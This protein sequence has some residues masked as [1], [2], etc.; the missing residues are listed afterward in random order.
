[1]AGLLDGRHVLVVEDES[2][3][4]M[5]IEDMLEDLGAASITVA[6]NIGVALARLEVGAFDFVVLDLSL[7]GVLTYPVAD[8]LRSRAIPFAF[9]TGYGAIAL[10][11]GY[12]GETA[13]HKPFTAEDLTQ[14]I[15][16]LLS[17]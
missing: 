12:E 13:L 6:A 8:T 2:L 10:A 15:E 16:K 4:S 1:M 14:V 17:R 11:Q 5:L 7:A 9:A 3:V